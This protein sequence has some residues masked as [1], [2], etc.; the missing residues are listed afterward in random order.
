MNVNVDALPVPLAAGISAD[1]SQAGC[2]SSKPAVTSATADAIAAGPKEGYEIGEPSKAPAVAEDLGEGS[3]ELQILVRRLTD[4]EPLKLEVKGQD[5]VADVKSL[6]QERLG[7]QP[8]EQKLLIGRMALQE[9]TKA[10]E[11]YGVK[12][13]TLLTLLVVE[14]PKEEK[15]MTTWDVDGNSR[16]DQL[17]GSGG[18]LTC[19]SLRQDYI[20]VVTKAPIV[21]GRHYFQF[22]MHMI[23]D[24][25]WVG[26]TPLPEQANSNPYPSALKGWI[27]Y[28][29]RMGSSLG[30]SGGL[31]FM[32]SDRESGKVYKYPASQTQPSGDVIGMAIDL[33]EGKIAFDL[34]GTH[35][36]GDRIPIEPLWIITTVD[37]PEDSIEVQKRPLSEM[38]ENSLAECKPPAST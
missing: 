1:G 22:K 7:V 31:H 19:P 36:G 14:V 33:D 35:V 18:L 38:P 20:S 6:I 3:Q 10:V 32:S 29:G 11:E 23:M 21:K 8:Q 9:D 13:G 5:T 30:G 2:E 4:K 26:V 28:C 34:N 12:E 37:R 15:D 16:H 17:T 25:E 27:Y 24:E